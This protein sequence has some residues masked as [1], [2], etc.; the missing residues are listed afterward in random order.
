VEV[1]VRQQAERG[2]IVVRDTGIGISAEFLPRVFEE[3]SQEVS[4]YGRPY[5]GTGLGLSLAK[6]FVE[7]SGGTITVESRKGR[8]SAFTLAFPLTGAVP[9]SSAPALPILLVEDDRLTREF[10]RT[11]LGPDFTVHT[12]GDAAEARAVLDR[13]PVALILM[14]LTLAGPVDGLELTRQLRRTERWRATP[15]IAVTAHASDHA[16]E[17]ALAAGCDA[18]LVK[19]LDSDALAATMRG[20]LRR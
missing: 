5:E 12:A 11:L 6:K 14:D 4:G 10:M 13:E 7:A 1:R 17:D 15:I 19:P 16:R 9:P 20:L 18:Y 2:V 8:G 3:F